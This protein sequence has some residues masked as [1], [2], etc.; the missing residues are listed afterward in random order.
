MRIPLVFLRSSVYIDLFWF[1]T[2]IKSF[3]MLSE[4]LRLF[5]DFVA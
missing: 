3:D 4:N 1:G 2:L 5:L